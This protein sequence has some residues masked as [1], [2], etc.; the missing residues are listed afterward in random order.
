MASVGAM[1]A[2]SNRV[3]ACVLAVA[4]LTAAPGV[5]LA[6]EP[7][8]PVLELRAPACVFHPGPVAGQV[9]VEV[10]LRLT[11]QYLLPDSVVTGV[12]IARADDAQD[13]PWFATGDIPVNERGTLAFAVAYLLEPGEFLPGTM[14]TELGLSGVD[15]SGDV[16]MMDIEATA[17]CR[18]DVEPEPR[19]EPLPGHEPEPGPGKVRLSTGGSRI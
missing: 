10:N 14:T 11:G 4:A 17:A 5:A 16:F 13:G 12:G 2:L 19:P 18:N 8:A 3:A 15:A 9:T 7:V 6:D 1:I